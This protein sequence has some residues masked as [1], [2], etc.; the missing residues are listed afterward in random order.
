MIYWSYIL[1][2]D[3]MKKLFKK[4]IAMCRDLPLNFVI[5]ELSLYQREDGSSDNIKWISKRI[6]EVTVTDS[7]MDLPFED[8]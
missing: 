4:A 8:A 1:T 6:L 5:V 3:K 2:G 7:A